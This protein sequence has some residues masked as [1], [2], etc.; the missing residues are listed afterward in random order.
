MGKLP[1]L[2]IIMSQTELI[3]QAGNCSKLFLCNLNSKRDLIDNKTHR[4][5]HGHSYWLIIDNNGLQGRIKL[6][7]ILNASLAH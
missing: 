2:C 4:E 1:Y 5:Q 7:R 6:W 3:G